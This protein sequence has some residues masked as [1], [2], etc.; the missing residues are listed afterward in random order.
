LTEILT[1]ILTELLTEILTELLTELLTTHYILH[2]LSGHLF[3][4]DVSHYS[5]I[6]YNFKIG[7]KKIQTDE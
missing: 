3:W 2:T 7:S 5:D 6:S 1:E 4:L